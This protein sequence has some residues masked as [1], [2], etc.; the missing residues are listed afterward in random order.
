[1]RVVKTALMQELEVNLKLIPK[2]ATS[3]CLE[4]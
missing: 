1:M 3:F 4:I 2:N